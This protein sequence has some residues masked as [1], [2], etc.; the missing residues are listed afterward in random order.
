MSYKGKRVLVIGGSGFV[1]KHLLRE[2]SAQN[3][4]VLQ[5]SK[6]PEESWN[7]EEFPD[8]E[9]VD[10]NIL[11]DEDVHRCISESRPD[12]LFHLA[13]QSSVGVSFQKPKLTF[14][15][16]L[17]GTL[18]VLESV[19]S[20]CPG[21]RIL[22]IGTAEQYGIVD[23]SDLPIREDFPISPVSPYAVSKMAAE[24]LAMAYWKNYGIQ[25][26]MVRSFN[27]IGP[28]QAPGFVVSSFSRQVAL[29]ENGS[30]EAVMKVGNLAA[31]RD[32][33]DVRDIVR[34]YRILMIKGA[35]GEIYNVG[36]GCFYSVQYILDTLLSLSE[37]DI[38]IQIDPEKMRP[39]DIPRVQADIGKVKQNTGWIPE[40]PIEIS[41]KDTLAY[42]RLN[43]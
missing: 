1:G 20:I 34:C 15:I 29:I 7:C 13:A 17:I 41:L 37:K 32:F 40:I 39:L 6:L 3:P 18:S 38:R 11:S 25:T 42:W 19:R 2:L 14:E 9:A 27:N 8:V 4:A 10:L 21:C 36:S 43:V 5:V 22:F 28:G 26:I 12:Y 31:E 33:T 30:Q 23:P 24:A 35:A 16:N